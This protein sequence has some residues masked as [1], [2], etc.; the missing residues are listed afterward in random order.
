MKPNPPPM[1]KGKAKRAAQKAKDADTR[2]ELDGGNLAGLRQALVT[3]DKVSPDNQ[4]SLSP[5]GN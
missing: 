2:H 1:S 4:A 3:A 5:V